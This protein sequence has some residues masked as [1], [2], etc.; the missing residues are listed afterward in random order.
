MRELYL[1][2]AM[3]GPSEECT[4]GSIEWAQRI[5]GR[6]QI[7]T[8]TV[9]S[10]T[11]NLLADTILSIW[12]A[13]PKPWEIWPEDHPFKT[14]DDYCQAITGHTWDGLFGALKEFGFEGGLTE[15]IMRADLA[16][17]QA[18]HR[19]QGTRTD[20]LPYK[21][22]K[23]SDK[24]GDGGTGSAYLLRRLARDHPDI[25]EQYERSEFRSVRAA[26]IA[27]GIVK[28]RIRRCPQCG[29]EW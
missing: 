29:H 12:Q 1:F 18:K 10:N 8:K 11:V 27:A 3:L 22:R 20:R 21:I 2:P 26:A 6:L 16:R 24:G 25:L 13:N 4:V 17:A 7:F 9:S 28:P 15:E 19:K 5:S 23:S 14:P